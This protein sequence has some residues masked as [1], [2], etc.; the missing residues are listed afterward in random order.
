[1]VNAISITNPANQAT[2]PPSSSELPDL[3][4]IYA[5]CRAMLDALPRGSEF[6]LMIG[7]R[8]SSYGSYFDAAVVHESLRFVSDHRCVST[9]TT[10]HR[11]LVDRLREHVLPQVQR[12]L[13]IE[14]QVGQAE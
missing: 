14:E 3:P 6:S 1:M 7:Q 13:R 8:L 12:A 4:A 5:E 9:E 11:R 2:S 10:D